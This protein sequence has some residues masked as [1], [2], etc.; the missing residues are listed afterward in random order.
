M[1]SFIGYLPHPEMEGE[2]WCR[3]LHCPSLPQ[4]VAVENRS[5]KLLETVLAV[6][7]DVSLI[8]PLAAAQG[9]GERLEQLLS[10]NTSASPGAFSNQECEQ[11]VGRGSRITD[12]GQP[13]WRKCNRATGHQP[14]FLSL[15]I[16]TLTG[17][18]YTHTYMQRGFFKKK[19]KQDTDKQSAKH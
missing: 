8:D 6:L 16:R 14:C 9:S 5:S 17:S 3:V 4:R 12:T 7:P 11:G 13:S 15:H 1:N 18:E 10:L 2:N 19:D